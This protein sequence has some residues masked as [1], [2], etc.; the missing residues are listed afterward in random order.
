MPSLYDGFDQLICDAFRIQDRQHLKRKS[1]K[2]EPL[3]DWEA[4]RLVQALFDKVAENAP[5]RPRFASNQLWRSTREAKISD[6]NRSLE[7][8]LEKSV[9]VL[10]TKGTCRGGSTNVPSP[11]ESS[12]RTPTAVGASISSI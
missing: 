10:A 5:T 3:S 6:N 1:L 4:S 9:A 12:I 7:K 8:M 2:L 11:R